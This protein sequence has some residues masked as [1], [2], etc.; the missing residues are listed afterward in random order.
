M[1]GLVIAAQLFSGPPVDSATGGINDG[2]VVSSG[3]LKGDP[4]VEHIRKNRIG[5]SAEWI[6]VTAAPGS[7]DVEFI[8]VIEIGQQFGWQLLPSAV[9]SH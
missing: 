2:A 8:A 3:R 4:P 5:R 9:A 6:S 7:A 1:R